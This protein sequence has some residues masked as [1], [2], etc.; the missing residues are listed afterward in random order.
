[1]KNTF[2]YGRYSYDYYLQFSDR[3]T[4]GMVVYPNL[5]IIVNVPYG[6]TLVEVEEFMKRKWKWLDK[7]LRELGKYNKKRY[8]RRYVAGESIE[9]LGRQYMLVVESGGDKVKLEKGKLIVY[10][11]KSAK[12]SLHNKK[13]IE[14][15]IEKHRQ[16]TFK[17]LFREAFKKFDYES[18]PLLKIRIMQRRWGS[19]SKNGSVIA[20][21]PRLIEA[22]SEAIYY[23]IVHELCHVKN[24]KH[25]KDFYKEL[26]KRIPKWREIKEKLEVRYG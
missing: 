23:V 3:K 17:R 6:T 19:C 8:E 9:Y 20:L 22:P 4:L 11:S 24:K 13:L 15:W 26:E 16:L 2:E 10:S 7:Q 25:D 18:E 12:N 1:M 14:N 5:R 21:N